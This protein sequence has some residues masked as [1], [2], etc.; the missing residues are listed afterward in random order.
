MICQT[1]AILA[2]DILFA[3]GA[4]AKIYQKHE[5]IFMEDAIPRYY[6]QIMKGNV[7]MYHIND[8]GKEFTQ[9]IFGNGSCFGEPMLF[10]EETYPAAAV[11]LKESVILKLSKDRF[12]NMLHHYPEIHM[13]LTRTLAQKI[14]HKSVSLKEY[15]NNAPEQKLIGFLNLYKKETHTNGNKTEIPYTR[16][17]I[18]NFTGLRVETVIRALLKMHTE[19]KLIIEHKKIYY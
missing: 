9:G 4:S 18:A 16:Q 8:E 5:I 13:L 15:I 7:K 19:G 12:F 6:Y 14:Y 10:I 3:Y 1:P 2:E 11:A 17:E